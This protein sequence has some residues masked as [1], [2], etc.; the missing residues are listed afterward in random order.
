MP[1]APPRNGRPCSSSSSNS[2]RRP[3]TETR[4]GWAGQRSADRVRAGRR[5][6]RRAELRLVCD[7]RELTYDQIADQLGISR[8]TL[9][10]YRVS[11]FEKFGIKSKTGLVLFAMRWGL[12]E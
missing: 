5:H 11:L 3:G 1:R 12:V 4:D 6:R 9:E 2:I 8:N 7:E 10:N